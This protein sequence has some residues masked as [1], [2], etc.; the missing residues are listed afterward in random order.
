MFA[1]YCELTSHKN[2]MD[3]YVLKLQVYNSVAAELIVG[4]Q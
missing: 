2:W 4:A 1:H 3:I